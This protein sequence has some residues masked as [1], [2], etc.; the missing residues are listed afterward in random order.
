MWISLG[1]VS[2]VGDGRLPWRHYSHFWNIPSFSKYKPTRVAALSQSAQGWEFSG[3]VLV[4]SFIEGLLWEIHDTKCYICM[5]S[6]DLQNT[7]ALF[8]FSERKQRLCMVKWL[9]QVTEL[10]NGR[11]R[12]SPEIF[13]NL[14]LQ[15]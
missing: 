2:M 7:Y 12:F 10:V 9:P 4:L 13:W 3:Y 15:Y 14:S 1:K 8:P 5:N 6:L 11:L